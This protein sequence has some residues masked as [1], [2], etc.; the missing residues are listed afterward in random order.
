MMI[1]RF[2]KMENKDEM[3]IDNKKITSEHSVKLLGTQ[4]DNQLNLT[5]M[6]QHYAKKVTFL[7]LNIQLKYST[8]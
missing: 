3:Y 6:Y 8:Y 4:I 1:N 5:I 2:R 7:Q